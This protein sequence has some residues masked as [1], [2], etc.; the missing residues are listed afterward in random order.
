MGDVQSIILYG[1]SYSVELRTVDST[2]EIKHILLV[3]EVGYEGHRNFEPSVARGEVSKR[4]A[5]G[6]NQWSDWAAS[7]RSRKSETSDLWYGRKGAIPERR[8]TE[9]HTRNAGIVPDKGEHFSS[10]HPK[11]LLISLQKL[12]F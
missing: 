12:S 1:L 3:T 7:E 5:R 9:G 2:Y 10:F 8:K 6:A 4:T 11:I